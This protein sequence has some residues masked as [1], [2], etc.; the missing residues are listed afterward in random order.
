MHCQAELKPVK[1]KLELDLELSKLA[2]P[3]PSQ[4]QAG[5]SSARLKLELG[6][7]M[8]KSQDKLNPDEAPLICIPTFLL[9]SDNGFLLKTTK[10]GKT[11]KT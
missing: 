6:C 5:Q 9:K 4:A 3:N 10:E 11:Q 1:L 7:L 8:L 2:W